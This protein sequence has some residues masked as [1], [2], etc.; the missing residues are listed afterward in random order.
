M[1][2]NSKKEKIKEIFQNNGIVVKDEHEILDLDSLSFLSLLID[3]EE[4]LKFELSEVDSL[5]DI[6]KNAYTF[7]K[8]YDCIEKYI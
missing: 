1:E 4:N 3:L 5:F 6:D 2:I 7:I 8:I